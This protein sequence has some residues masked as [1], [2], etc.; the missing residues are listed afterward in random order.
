[1]KKKINY[2]VMFVHVFLVLFFTVFGAEKYFLHK[3]TQ[4]LIENEVKKERRPVQFEAYKQIFSDKRHTPY[5]Y[6]H[7]KNIKVKLEKG[8]YESTFIT[9]SEGLRETQNYSYLKKSIVFLGDSVVEGASVNNEETMDSILEKRIDIPVLNFGVSS[10]GIELAYKYL[11]SKYKAEYNAK[12]VFLGYCVNDFEAEHVVRYFNSAAGTW[13]FYRHYNELLDLEKGNCAFIFELPLLGKIFYRI[14]DSY[15]SSRIRMQIRKL[16]YINIEHE[17]NHITGIRT[18]KITLE[19]REYITKRVLYLMKEFNTKI[20]SEFVVI[21]FPYKEQV[22]NMQ[23]DYGES[24]QKRHVIPTLNKLNIKYIDLY[25]PIKN[26]YQFSPNKKWYH[27]Y[28]HFSNYG[29]EFIGNFLASK[30]FLYIK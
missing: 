13:A 28:M 6:G 30:I 10:R 11:K 15:L 8:H 5:K 23:Y 20:Q 25:E 16:I 3:E 29:H 24:V 21:L 1:M 4:Y 7:K 18:K 27:D 17:I 9:N 26:A 19:Q 12:L 14:Y 2:L 22:I